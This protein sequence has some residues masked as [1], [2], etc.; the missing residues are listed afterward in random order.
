MRKKIAILTSILF[1]AVACALPIAASEY[2]KSEAKKVSKKDKLVT[3]EK[4]LETLTEGEKVTK[5]DIAASVDVI[6]EIAVLKEQ[7]YPEEYYQEQ[8][9]STISTTDAAVF[10]MER[11]LKAGAVP[12]ENQIETKDRIAKF[13]AWVDS[14]KA[15]YESADP[16]SYQ[17]LYEKYQKQ[18]DELVEYFTEQY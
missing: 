9:E 14:L 2:Q 5:A 7:L 6:E 4:Q 17:A 10:D 15:E 16:Q 12:E 1:V 18:S 8:I 11:D 13:G 3:L